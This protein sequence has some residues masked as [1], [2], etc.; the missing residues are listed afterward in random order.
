MAEIVTRISGKT[1]DGTVVG[2]AQLVARVTTWQVKIGT[3]LRTAADR[4]DAE[5]QLTKLGAVVFDRY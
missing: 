1:N 4:K 2:T 3:E 5:D